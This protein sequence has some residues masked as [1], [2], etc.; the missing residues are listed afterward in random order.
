MREAVGICRKH[1]RL[2]GDAERAYQASSSHERSDMRECPGNPNSANASLMGA[3]LA[4]A[5]RNALQLSNSQP[6]AFSRRSRA[7]GV[8][9]FSPRRMRGGSA[10]RGAG[11]WMGR[12]PPHDEP[13]RLSARHRDGFGRGDRA[14]GTASGGLS[15]LFP[16]RVQPTKRGRAL[17]MG[18]GRWP[19]AS[20]GVLARHARGTPHPAPLPR[21]LMTAPPREQDNKLIILVRTYVKCC[22]DAVRRRTRLRI[23][24]VAHKR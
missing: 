23:P 7:R 13:R 24:D 21:R 2:A 22:C 19:P 3:M 9:Q 4:H 16:V 8:R 18:P 10:P 5:A 17:V 11:W 15:P 1:P 6:L 20:R 12:D 14:S